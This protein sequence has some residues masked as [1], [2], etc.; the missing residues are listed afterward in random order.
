MTSTANQARTALPV[1]TVVRATR[2]RRGSAVGTYKAIVLGPYGP[3]GSASGYRLWFFRAGAA[4][5]GTGALGLAFHGEATAIGSLDGMSER[6]L[7]A[8]VQGSNGCSEAHSVWMEAS[9]VWMRKR[10]ARRAG[11]EDIPA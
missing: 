8:V 2:F 5:A 4:R 3:D 11:R 1:G 6:T 10:A 7:R 9:K